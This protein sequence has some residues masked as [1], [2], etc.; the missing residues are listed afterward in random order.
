MK[1]RSSFSWAISWVICSK[2][3]SKS[4]M[5][6]SEAICVQVIPFLCVC[7]SVWFITCLATLMTLDDKGTLYYNFFRNK[8]RRTARFLWYILV[9]ICMNIYV[10]FVRQWL[11]WVGFDFGPKTSEVSSLFARN[12]KNNVR[13]TTDCMSNFHKDNLRN[14]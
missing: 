12:V 10:V 4:L 8:K 14:I 13:D 6:V 1:E 5:C 3:S 11:E 7:L 2:H 9:H